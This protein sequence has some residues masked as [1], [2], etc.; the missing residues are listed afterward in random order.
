MEVNQVNI[1]T[2]LRGKALA[3]VLSVAALLCVALVVLLTQS[4]P[5]PADVQLNNMDCHGHVEKAPD[6]EDD[7]GATQVR[8]D[9]ACNGPI[10]GYQIQPNLEVQSMET[11]VFGVDRKSN[12]PYPNDSFS[13]SGDLPGFGIN[14]VGFAGFLDNAKRTYDPSVKSYV[15][16]SGT[17]SIDEDICAE[18]RVNPLLT[19]MTAG[20]D[21]KGNPTQAISGPYDMGRPIKTGCKLSRKAAKRRIPADGPDTDASDSDVGRR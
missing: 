16:I 13:C 4:S 20:I 1:A 8:Y 5:A 12:A 19:V 14:C 21:S 6:S 10:T 9:F 2:S 17:F 3:G 15:L 18:P 7:P 11:E